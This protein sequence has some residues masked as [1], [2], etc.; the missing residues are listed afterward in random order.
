MVICYLGIGSNLGNRPR[1]I[2]TAVE[3]IA[4]LKD[5]KIIKLS[6]LI[7][8]SPVG[9]PSGQNKFLNAAL[10][11]K[12]GLSPSRLLVGLK[13][14]ERQLGRKRAPRWG[15]RT[16]D[17]DILLYGSVFINRK[18]LKIPHRKM[19]EREFVM[20]PLWEIL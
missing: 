3:K 1:Y 13:K 19:F 2:K 20:R 5:T 11:I 14:I 15:A 18:N 7:E 12:T 10:K 8:T 4:N 16:V 6:K 9:G 17:L